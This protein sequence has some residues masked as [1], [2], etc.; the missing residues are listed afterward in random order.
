MDFGPKFKLNFSLHDK[1]VCAFVYDILL[2]LMTSFLRI[3]LML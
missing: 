3:K 2:G 1:H